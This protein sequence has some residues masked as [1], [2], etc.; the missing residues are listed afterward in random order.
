MSFDEE[1]VVGGTPSPL[2]GR[3]FDTGKARWSLFPAGTL[4]QILE[5][6][7]I[8]A[9][10]YAPDNWKYVPERRTRYYDALHRHVEAWWGGEKADPETGRSHLAHAACCILFLMWCDRND[11]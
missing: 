1:L 6:L 5:V 9:K 11:K 10:K 4:L 3:K 2:E 8:G 7:E